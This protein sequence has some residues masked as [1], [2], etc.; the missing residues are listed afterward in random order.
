MRRDDDRRG[1]TM[2]GKNIN[3]GDRCVVGH[4]QNGKYTVWHKVMGPG[5]R[6]YTV[7]KEQLAAKVDELL[8]RWKEQ[9]PERR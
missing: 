9:S 4:T 3:E 7:S 8:S 6:P 5:T 2:A 1:K